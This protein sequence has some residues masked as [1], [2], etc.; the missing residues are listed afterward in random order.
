MNNLHELLESIQAI[1]T[2]RLMQKWQ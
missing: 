2:V 1:F